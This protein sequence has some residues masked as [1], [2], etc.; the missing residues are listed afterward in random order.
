MRLKFVVLFSGLLLLV[1]FL[2][3]WECG[4]AP[5]AEQIQH[6]KAGEGFPP[7]PLPATPLRRSEKKNPPSPPVLV[8]KVVCGSDEKWTRAENDVENLLRV[9][10]LQMGVPYRSVKIS[11]DKFSFDP[12]EI[13]I[14]YIT[15]VEPFTPD[16]KLFP[17]IK[18][19]LEKGGFIWLNA[20]SGS[21]DF[22]KSA[23]EWLSKIYPDRNL[24]KVYSNHPL[25]TC[26]HDISSV[27]IMKEGVTG[28]SVPGLMILNLG[29]RAAVILSDCDLGCGW[30][31]H[32]HQ[33]GT[34]YVP[35]D[36][37]KIGSNMLSYC[38]GWI[39][40]G[41]QFGQTSIYS[42][43][44]SKKE[45]KLYVGQVI[46]SGD[47]DPHPAALGRLLKM[48]S[49]NTSAPVYLERLSVDLKKD[50]LKDIPLLYM[51]GHFNPGLGNEELAKLRTFF[52]SG[53]TLIAD[54]CCGSAEFTGSFRGIVSKVLP[55]AKRVVW[56][57]N[58]PVYK[59]PFRIDGFTY[60]VPAENSPP[61]EAYMLNGLPAIVFS[62]YGIGDGWEGVPRPYAKIFS[63]SR[64]TDLGVNLITYLMTH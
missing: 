1:P 31:M 29:C 5:P 13:P 38:L 18:D 35:E 25:V 33:W 49:Q 63:P 12:D 37:V 51:T 3:A 14:L 15:S 6:R 2:Y 26:F 64:S 60:T 39:E 59:I 16:G 9:S 45:G 19:Y 42:E 7:L 58:H 47:W 10:S 55:E 4:K 23:F 44:I 54:S 11:L 30:A 22:A 21:P 27:K 62:P 48:V 52:L 50:D 40:F 56:D 24:H 46:H 43:K 53:G 34:R 36:A 20:S 28:V 8:G 61:L 41:K 57:S 17:K 32:T